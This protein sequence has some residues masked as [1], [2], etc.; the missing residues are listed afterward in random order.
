[1]RAHVQFFHD[2]TGWNG[3]DYSGPV[4]LIEACGSDSVAILDGRYGRA[5]QHDEARRILAL[6]PKYNAYQLRGGSSLLN[7]RNMSEVI[8]R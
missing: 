3:K 4:K 7:S 5:R 8:L 6:R 1:M 2:S